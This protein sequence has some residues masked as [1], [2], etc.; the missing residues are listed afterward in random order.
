M[1]LLWAGVL[2]AAAV[3]LWS[4]LWRRRLKVRVFEALAL[5]PVFLLDSEGKVTFWNE[6]AKTAFGYSRSEILG[7]TAERLVTVPLHGVTT[8]RVLETSVQRSDGSQVQVEITTTPAKVRGKWHTIVVVRDASQHQRRAEELRL[9]KERAEQAAAELEAVNAVL[10]RTTVWANEMAARTAMANAAKSEFLA[11]MSHEIRTP[12]NGV[13]GM[14]TLLEQT[15]L[16]RE[17][18]DYVET[19]RYS[20]QILLDLI[21]QI[22]EYSRIESGKLELEQV[23]FDPR[24]E[25]EQA[26]L[27]FAERAD[28]KGIEL[29]AA[30]P[31]SVP[32]RLRG[33]ASRFRQILINLLGNAVKFTERGEVSVS[34][35]S[36]PLE[37][38]R[39][40][41]GVEVRDTGIGMPP[42]VMQ[43]LFQAFYQG[44]DSMRR[45]GGTGLGLTICKKLVEAMNG[46]I[47]VS[48]SPG[49]G[50]TF[51]FTIQT[52]TARAAAQPEPGQ[53][54]LSGARV[55]IVHGN[56]GIRSMICS[57]A[58]DWGMEAV[59]AES[60]QE[61]PDG[62]Y[63]FVI[64]DA[65]ASNL[66]PLRRHASLLLLVARSDRR[67]A[68][69][70]GAAALIAKPIRASKLRAALL[71]LAN[72]SPAAPVPAAPGNEVV[73]TAG[74]RIL[75]VEDNL[76]NQKVA[77]KLAEKL[78]YTVEIANNGEAAVKAAAAGGY[79]AVLMDCQ[80]PVMDGF[81]ATEAIRR[82]PEPQGLVP[83]IAMTANAMRGDREKCLAAGMSDYLAK[84]VNPQELKAALER[85]CGKTHPKPVP[86]EEPDW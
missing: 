35:C 79:A 63:R 22:L 55:L 49:A 67:T 72:P 41:L 9:A 3:V 86:V 62:S 85:W 48:S 60:P 44:E 52:E 61:A 11:S 40:E 14:L 74:P 58:E 42:E 56:A 68:E 47:E 73:P 77:L 78:G 18:L 54:A 59:E 12:M 31:G 4:Q 75:V 39:V 81:K 6:A 28:A 2:A 29:L 36:T 65:Y 76:V 33:D 10:E 26:I 83:V 34:V 16:T 84:P 69:A 50:S 80:M 64:A 51:R 1:A 70:L 23:E 25:I 43:N 15:E 19:I 66:E 37:G 32:A 13:L 17:Q 27:L 24:H 7:R 53:E 20:G 71:E 21:N 45:F 82:L 5:D 57:C 38:G 8:R 46:R 30:V